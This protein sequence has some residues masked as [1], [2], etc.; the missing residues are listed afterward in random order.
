VRLTRYDVGEGRL[1]TL[2]LLSRLLALRAPH[3]YG[4]IEIDRRAVCVG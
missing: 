2:V 1:Q 4:G 3:R